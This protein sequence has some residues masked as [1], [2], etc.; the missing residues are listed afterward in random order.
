LVLADGRSE[1]VLASCDN[2]YPEG[3]LANLVKRRRQDGLDATLTLMKVTPAEMPT[4]AVVVMREGLIRAIVEKPDPDEAPSSLGV[5]ALYA[6]STRI[7]EYL[8]RVPV[9]SRGEREFPDALRLLIEDGGR[10]GGVMVDDRLT[11]TRPQD[12]LALSRVFLEGDPEC[13]VVAR[14]LPPDVRILPPVRIESGA[15]VGAGCTI[16]PEAVLESGSRVGRDAVIRRSV[17]TQ[18]ASVANGTV[19]ENAVLS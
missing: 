9:S 12:L 5:P 4:L 7:I 14:K 19:I 6:L 18:G 2:I 8:P 13:A 16:G 10:A 17:V 1:F 15:C 11:L 3:H